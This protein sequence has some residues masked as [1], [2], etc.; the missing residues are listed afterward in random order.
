[1]TLLL[2]I[3][4]QIYN[5]FAVAKTNYILQTKDELMSI[6]QNTWEKN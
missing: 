6:V 1:M 3:G 4:F 5:Y 2:I